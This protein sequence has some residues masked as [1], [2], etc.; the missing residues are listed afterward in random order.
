MREYRVDDVVFVTAGDAN[1]YELLVIAAVDLTTDGITFASGPVKAWSAGCRIAP[2]R[3]ATIGDKSSVSNLTDRVGETQ[4]RFNVEE[5]D[6][7][8]G[9]SWGYCSPLWRFPVDWANPIDVDHE[10]L[11]YTFDNETGLPSCGPG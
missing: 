9:E 4:A 3:I 10:R 2:M 1:D 5:P 8:F 7:G 6:S 11:T